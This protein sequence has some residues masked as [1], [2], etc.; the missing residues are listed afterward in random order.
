[1]AVSELR[2]LLDIDAIVDLAGPRF[3]E[4]GVGYVADGRVGAISEADDAIEASV[5]GTDAYS[6][7]I[8]AVDDR[9]IGI[10]SCPMGDSGAFCKHCVALSLAWI[11]EPVDAPDAPTDD[12]VETHLAGLDRDALID[13]ITDE[14]ARDGALAARIRLRAEATS[15]VGVR[16]LRQALVRATRVGGFLDYREVPTFAAEVEDVADAIER[17]IDAEHAEAIIDLA[18]F[19]I[20]RLESA[21]ES[22]D[23]SDGYFSMLWGRFG[24]IHLAAC[25]AAQPDPVELARRLFDLEMEDEWE[26]FAGAAERYADILGETGLAEYRRLGMEQWTTVPARGPGAGRYQDPAADPHHEFTVTYLMESV[27]RASGDMDELIAVMSRDLSSAYQYLQVAEVCRDAGRGDEALDWAERGVAAFPVR[28]DSR[29]REFL[30]DAYLERSR[31][32][33]AMTLVW[34]AFKEEPDLEAFQRLRRFAERTGTWDAWR[35][36][37]LETVRGAHGHPEAVGTTLVEIH[38][39]EEDLDAG[40]AVAR[41]YGCDHAILL[42][43]AKRSEDTHPEDALAAFKGE[44]AEVLKVA[45]RRNYTTAIGLLRRIDRLS[46][47]LDR[48]DEFGAYVARVRRDNARRPAFCSMFDA[49]GFPR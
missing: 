16:L 19:G 40:W 48:S 9:I 45:D 34:A 5:R 14:M 49:A 30:A 28:T 43:L 8:A 20:G 6:V 32:D 24:R 42:R 11:D 2:I 37:A 23:D 18:E 25:R 26:V 39:W 29:L 46:A 22:A 15:D 13:L 7:R 21:L 47:K 38:T 36:R 17:A 1:M 41:E 31:G 33:E 44:V 10:C 4:R 27:A 12:P 3:F 35:T